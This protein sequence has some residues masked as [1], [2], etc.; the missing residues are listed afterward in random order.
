MSNVKRSANN[1]RDSSFSSGFLPA[2][3]AAALFAS[4]VVSP[5]TARGGVEA[6]NLRNTTLLQMDFLIKRV[7][8]GE[9]FDPPTQKV[10]DKIAENLDTLSTHLM[11]DIKKEEFEAVSDR[12]YYAVEYWESGQ[13]LEAQAW[14]MKSKALLASFAF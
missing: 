6:Q 1:E 5:W 13:M 7:S 9:P 3:F 12:L 8:R 14:L 2:L 4:I 11:G 10:V